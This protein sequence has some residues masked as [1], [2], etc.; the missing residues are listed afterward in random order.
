MTGIFAT[1]VSAMI[2]CFMIVVPVLAS[3]AWMAG[4]VYE[5]GCEADVDLFPFSSSTEIE[6]TTERA[7]DARRERL[8]ER[9]DESEKIDPQP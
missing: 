3:K 6:R 5:L 2:L 4:I 8:I 7:T 9:D 1:L